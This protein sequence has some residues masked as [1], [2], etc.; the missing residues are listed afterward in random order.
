MKLPEN[1][2][3]RPTKFPEM[4]MR[5]RA[6][7]GEKNRKKQLRLRW[8]VLNS[9]IA[10]CI[11]L[12]VLVVKAVSLNRENARKEAAKVAAVEKKKKEAKQTPAP[13]A[14]PTPAP[15]GSE[16]WLRK[17]LDPSK[18]MIAL[19]FDDGPYSP[20]TEKILDVLEQNNGKATFFCVGSRVS[21]YASSV[22][23]A[24]NMGCEIASHTYSHVY[25]TGLKA[26][27]IKKEQSKTNKA[28][29]NIIGCE[30]TALRPPGGFVN[31]KVR[32]NMKVPMIC[33]SVDSEDWKSRNTK[34]ILKRCKKLEDGDI[35][36]MHDLYPTTAKAVKKL[37]PR[38][39]KQGFQLVTVDELFYY[40]GIPIKAGEL[41]F[42][43][44]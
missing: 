41:H 18:P 23:R 36:L 4:S 42:S 44:K 21:G 1:K 40:K 33:W 29:R 39:V 9:I 14:T 17:D 16:R 27:K 6:E 19:T 10:L 28:I 26:K 38:L 24:Y 43:G 30:P 37:V 25:L 22:L 15:V 11:I 7:I 20:V 32:K 5:Q 34:K 35:V 12:A 8:I 3:E 13:T 2:R 31:A